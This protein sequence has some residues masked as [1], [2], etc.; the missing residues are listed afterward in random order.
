MLIL[1]P[2]NAR[3]LF[4]QLR[5][6]HEIRNSSGQLVERDLFIGQTDFCRLTQ[7]D[8]QRTVLLVLDQNLRSL[9]LHYL[10]SV[11]AVRTHTGHDNSQHTGSIHVG[12]E[13][14]Q[15]AEL[16]SAVLLRRN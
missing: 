12:N 8:K 5:F 15:I 16:R 7:H 9:R 13:S 11:R 6:L 2:V 14:K 1:S 10:Q 4:L 3:W